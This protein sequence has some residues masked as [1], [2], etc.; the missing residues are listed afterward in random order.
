MSMIEHH[1]RPGFRRVAA[2]VGVAVLLLRAAI[3]PGLMID[4]ASAA[5]GEF[6]LIICTGGSPAVAGVMPGEPRTAPGE[7]D[8]DDHEKGDHG[9]CPYAASTPLAVTAQPAPFPTLD[10]PASVIAATAD[11]TIPVMPA[12]GADARAPPVWA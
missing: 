12:R 10:S 11:E 1:R 6:R 7:H 3:A 5:H 9:I 2:W 4:P 8:K